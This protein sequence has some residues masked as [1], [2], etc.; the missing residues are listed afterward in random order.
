MAKK[1][2]RQLDE[3]E[4]KMLEKL[5]AIRLPSHMIAALLEI[6]ETQLRYLK[7]KNDTV[8]R[9]AIGGRAKASRDVRTTLYHMA[10]RDKNFQALKFWCETQEDFKRADKLEISGIP[11]APPVQVETH[12]VTK[13]EL[14]ERLI[15]LRKANDLTED[16]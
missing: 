11:D 13:E 7:K 9:V 12:T 6:S 2:K 5:E 8:R 16:E 15:Q 14:K 3:R 1:P 10:V 4:L